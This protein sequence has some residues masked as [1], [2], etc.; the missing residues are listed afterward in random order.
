MT[1][2]ILGIDVPLLEVPVRPGRSLATIVEIAARR[3]VLFKEGYDA[4]E[5]LD[6]RLWDKY[7]VKN[8]E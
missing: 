1:E 4:A 5:E 6:R 3:W 8:G 7:S 2:S